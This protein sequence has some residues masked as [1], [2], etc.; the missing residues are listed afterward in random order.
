MKRAIPA[1]LIGLLAAASASGQLQTSY[2]ARMQAELIGV[3]TQTRLSVELDGVPAREAFRSVS[4]ALAT[5]VIG[6]Y[7][8]DRFGHGIDPEAPITFKAQDAPARL[9]LEM[10]L[11]QCAT[12]EPC[13]WQL[14]KGYIEVGTKE[15]LSFPAAAETRLYNVRDL[16][17][18]PPH[19]VAPH[20][21]SGGPGGGGMP[22]IALVM[23]ERGHGMPSTRT[24]APP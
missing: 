7:S 3:L 1:S 18:E 19:F 24:P 17:L 11:E 5:P 9:V 23:V 15:R 4:A 22:P 13:I 20:L 2:D 8:D 14:R 10:I 21:G 16:M 12:Y 6:R